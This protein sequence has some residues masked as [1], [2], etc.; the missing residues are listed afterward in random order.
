MLNLTTNSCPF[1]EFSGVNILGEAWLNFEVN[2]ALA[3]PIRPLLKLKHA[4][5]Q[6]MHP[7][8]QFRHYSD[9]YDI[10][11]TGTGILIRTI[12]NPSPKPN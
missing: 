8:G 5:K 2:K 11:V 6:R 1:D 10:I 12:A 7:L 9:D 3:L 4:S